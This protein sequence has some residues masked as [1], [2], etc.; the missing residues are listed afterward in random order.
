MPFV[1][2]GYNLVHSVRKLSEEFGAIS[3]LEVC[4]VCR[5]F[6]SAARQDGVIVF[7]GLGPVDK[8]AYNSMGRLAVVFSGEREADSVIED[9][10][11]E[12]S[13]PKR[14]VVV[15]TD[16]RVRRAAK[17]RKAVPVRSEEFWPAMLERIERE[18]KRVREPN[19]KRYGIP[20]HQIDRWLDLFGLD[21]ND[22]G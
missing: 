5:H 7:D 17:K 12:S 13:A 8:A 9:M 15:S 14:M 6:L 22:K 4:E 16:R 2:D 20:D 19:E 1:I 21:D 11:Q 18:A 3:D 10:I